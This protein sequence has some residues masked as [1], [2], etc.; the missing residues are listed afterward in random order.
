ML[1]DEDLKFHYIQMQG[2]TTPETPS[3]LENIFESKSDGAKII[4]KQVVS[5]E[6]NLMEEIKLLNKA[7]LKEQEAEQL[8]K[9]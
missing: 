8:K 7:R 3:R 4:R 9:R 1:W 6:K 2:E 5:Y